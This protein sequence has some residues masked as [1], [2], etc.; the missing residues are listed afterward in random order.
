MTTEDTRELTLRENLEF[1][2][3]TWA[4]Q[5]VGWTAVALLLVAALVGL[6]GEGPL[7]AAMAVDEATGFEVEYFRFVRHGAPDQLK[8]RVPAEAVDDSEARIE[9]DR[10][11]IEALTLEAIMPEPAS[12]EAMPESIAYL[13]RIDRNPGTKTVTFNVT[14]QAVGLVSVRVALGGHRAVTFNQFVYP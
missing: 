12:V 2:N 10:E 5:R 7:S 11:Y 1:H 14:H 8:M 3:R 9:L 4:F 13:F 6:T